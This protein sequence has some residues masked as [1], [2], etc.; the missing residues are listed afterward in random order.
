[1]EYWT[2]KYI[3]DIGVNAMP[4]MVQNVL[5]LSINTDCYCH[6]IEQ[7]NRFLLDSE[8]Y[9]ELNAHPDGIEVSRSI[10]VSIGAR[11]TI[12]NRRINVSHLERYRTNVLLARLTKVRC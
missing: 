12:S 6:H 4:I 5:S 7:I 9:Q 3:C 1:M 8:E 10:L 2:N 11:R